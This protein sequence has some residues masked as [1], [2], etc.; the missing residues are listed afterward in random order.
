MTVLY[1]TNN[2]N[3]IFLYYTDIVYLTVLYVT[4]IVICVLNDVDDG[5]HSE[6]SEHAFRKR[7]HIF[8]E[9][10]TVWGRRFEAF[11]MAVIFITVTEITKSKWFFITK[12]SIKGEIRF[13]K[14]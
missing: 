1:Y 5:D 6:S 4:N 9:A 10:R 11:I 13:S 3:L 14:G 12:F 7:L 2:V 8:L